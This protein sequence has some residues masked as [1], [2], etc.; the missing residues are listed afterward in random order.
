MVIVF[1]GLEDWIYTLNQPRPSDAIVNSTISS[2]EFS[3]N[4]SK[5]D[6]DVKVACQSIDT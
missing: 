4:H 5:S 1:Y 2:I 6:R 3:F